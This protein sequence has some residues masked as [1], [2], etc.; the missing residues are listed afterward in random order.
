M[1]LVVL[2]LL[3]SLFGI[4]A[5]AQ[6]QPELNDKTAPVYDKAVEALNSGAYGRAM[7][8]FDKAIDLDSSQSGFWYG[9]ASACIRLNRLNDAREAIDQAIN[10]DDKQAAYFN[11]AGNISFQAKSLEA[12][13]DEFSEAIKLNEKALRKIDLT[14]TFYNKGLCHLMQK[15]YALAEEE[16]TECLKINP[17]FKNALHNRGVARLR[18]DKKELACEDFNRAYGMG[19]ARSR[20]YLEDNCE[21]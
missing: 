10:L 13:I 21:N 14:Y 19:S 1:R 2:L 20:E 18:Q 12:A 17:G 5:K 16:F 15:D 7:R 8:L 6:S 11:L 9:K 3:F 4:I